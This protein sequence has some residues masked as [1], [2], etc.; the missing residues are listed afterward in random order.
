MP[1]TLN[2]DEERL[3]R[4]ARLTGITDP[5]EL[6][7]RGLDALLAREASRRLADLAGSQPD[8]EVPGRPV[9]SDDE[10]R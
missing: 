9:P 2:I 4:A 8:F 3:E 6:I 1:T 7:H 5:A 10:S